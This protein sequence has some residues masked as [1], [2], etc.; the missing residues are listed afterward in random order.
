MWKRRKAIIVSL[1]IFCLWACISDLIITSLSSSIPPAY[2][3]PLRGVNNL[4]VPATAFFILLG[5]DR[6]HGYSLS[7]SEKQY[8]T[9]FDSNPN[10]MWVFDCDTLNFIAVNDAAVIKYGYSRDEFLQMTIMDIRPSSD[11]PQLAEAVRKAKAEL[12]EAGNWM[13][14]RKSG[15]AFPVSIT[16]HLVYFN[17][18]HCR[19]VMATDITAQLEHEKQLQEAY[20]K[21]KELHKKLIA[22]FQVLKK[23]EHENRLMGEVIDKINNIVLIVAEGGNIVRVNQAFID[24]TGY[25]REEVIGRNPGEF[26]I[27]AGTDK[28]TINR[29]VE[30]VQRKEFFHGEL[31][32]YKKNGELYWTQISLTPIFNE[33]GAFQFFISVE[34]VITEKKEREQKILAQ[35]ATLQRIAWANS[36]EIRRPV[37]SIMGLVSL[38]KSADDYE[39]KNKCLEALEK[40]SKELD[41]M[42]T[43]I[44]NETERMHLQDLV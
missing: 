28:Q 13:H 25:T 18:K 30:T 9:L 35:H 23:T 5:E 20:R 37:C 15:E 44:N 41:L 36:H 4:I 29:L 1:V 19:M 2:I 16:S 22:N 21:E 7:P 40:C 39:E 12:N 32:N 17:G 34:T 38:L 33:N 10:P 27:G 31:M 42:I 8:R 14:I 11:R 26:L 3:E 43:N 6:K 24:F